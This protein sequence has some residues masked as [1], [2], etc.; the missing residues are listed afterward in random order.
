M[1]QLEDPLSQALNQAPVLRKGTA[2]RSRMKYRQ[3]S[4]QCL[5][6]PLGSLSRITAPPLQETRPDTAGHS[7]DVATLKNTTTTRGYSTSKDTR[8]LSACAVRSAASINGF[9]HQGACSE[10]KARA[11]CTASRPPTR[12][13]TSP[14]KRRFSSQKAEWQRCACRHTLISWKVQLQLAG[15]TIGCGHGP[16]ALAFL[17]PRFLLSVS[18]SA[19]LAVASG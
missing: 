4:V 11:S 13:R 3:A 14:H 18:T 2:Q 19:P 15:T 17:L 1:D 10:H 7:H 8:E 16:G 9:Q 12:Q 5:G 6:W